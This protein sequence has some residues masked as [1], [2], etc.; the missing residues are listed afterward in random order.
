MRL[1]SY[2]IHG[3]LRLGC[4]RKDGVI[5][6]E[7]AARAIGAD[8]PTDMVG[9]IERGDVALDI[10]E[11]A[12]KQ[13]QAVVAAPVLGPPIP[14]AEKSVYAVGRN[15]REHVNE[16]AK[17]RRQAVVD[18]AYVTF[19]SKAATCLI[20]HE[21]NIEL[22]RHATSQLDYEVELVVVIGRAGR[23][24][25]A[26]SAY[27]HI[28]GYTIGNDIS[29]RDAQTNHGQW[30]KGKSMDTFG[31]VG[32]FIVPARYFGDPQRK[33]I[34]L[35]VNGSSRQ[36]ASTADMIFDI[37]TIVHQLSLGMTLEPG[38]LIMTGT[39]AGVALGMSPPQWLQP[40]DVIE[41]EIQGIG[42]L[43]NRVIERPSRG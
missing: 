41:A 1:V 31:P 17:A 26:D 10:A 27:E 4:L 42:V 24:I 40:G 3:G 34:S 22:D 7:R 43:R 18:S 20:G 30:F 36:D 8:L 32:P 2:Q 11:A 9:F 25:P 15:Y 37:P 19:F 33:R 16:A 6:L 5:D 12:L 29:A 39:P 14:A 28:Y 23:N 35:R 38:D 13:G 21:G